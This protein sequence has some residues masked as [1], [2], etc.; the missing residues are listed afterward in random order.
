MGHM[1]IYP[2]VDP[3]PPRKST[4]SDRIGR[5]GW[6]FNPDSCTEGTGLSRV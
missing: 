5:V 3:D 2:L 4:G 6:E 1:A